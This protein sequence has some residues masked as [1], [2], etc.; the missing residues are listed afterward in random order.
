MCTLHRRCFLGLVGGPLAALQPGLAFS[1]APGRQEFAILAQ[2]MKDQAMAAGDQPYGAVLVVGEAVVGHG[3]SRVVQDR[4]PQAH[5][6]RVAL[7]D[8]QARLGRSD[9]VDAVVYAT[10]VPCAECQQ[11]LAAARV[12]RMYVGPAAT[13]AGVP[14]S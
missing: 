11:A 9:L 10:S 6:E 8:A 13:D 2:S 3:P 1:A 14:R 5:A 12:G 4:N 7:W